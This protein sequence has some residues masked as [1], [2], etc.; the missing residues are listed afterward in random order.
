[1]VLLLVGLQGVVCLFC[2]VSALWKH[3]CSKY[4]ADVA[5]RLGGNILV[6][7]SSMW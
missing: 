2:G 3:F 7:V 5:E 4:V 6:V 1:M